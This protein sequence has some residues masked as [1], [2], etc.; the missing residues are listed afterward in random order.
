M[1]SILVVV[2]LLVMAALISTFS[3][4]VPSPPSKVSPAPTV[5]KEP[6]NVSPL[7]VPVRVSALVVS[8]QVILEDKYLIFKDF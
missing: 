3:V 5:V 7:A 6:A 8:G 1:F 4:S 2:N